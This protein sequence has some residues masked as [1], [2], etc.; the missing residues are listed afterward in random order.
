MTDATDPAKPQPA[1]SSEDLAETDHPT[2]HD[3]AA[4]NR[5]EESPA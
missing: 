2:G 5:E 1:A 4:R 3:D